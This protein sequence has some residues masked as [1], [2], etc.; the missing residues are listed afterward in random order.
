MSAFL[1]GM[2]HEMGHTADDFIWTALGLYG[3]DKVA[4]PLVLSEGDGEL[5]MLLK[6]TAVIVGLH[7]AV[8]VLHQ[9][10]LLPS[11]FGAY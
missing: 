2:E 5:I 10:G 3:F 6:Q 7:E 11:I 4:K 8:R 1:S 9:K